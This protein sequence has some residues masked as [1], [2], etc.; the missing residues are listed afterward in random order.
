[1]HTPFEFD[2][3]LWTT[4]E[5]GNKHYWVRVKRTGEVC[6]VDHEVMKFLRKEEKKLRREFADVPETGTILSLDV[7]HDDEKSSWFEDNGIGMSAMETAVYEKEFLLTLTNAEQDV[8]VHCII[9]DETATGYGK[10]HGKTQQAVTATIS[11]I[12]KKAKI[13]FA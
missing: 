6:E 2:Y 13:F 8:F 9:G 7:P 3:D 1:M 5:N 12:R 4:E 10:A 11:R